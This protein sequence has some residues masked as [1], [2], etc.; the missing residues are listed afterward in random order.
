MSSN[1]VFI[2]FDNNPVSTTV[3]SNTSNEAIPAGQYGLIIPHVTTDG[4]LFI[5]DVEA[6]VR[7]GIY[8]GSASAQASGTTIYNNTTT[9]AMIITVA[10]EPVAGATTCTINHVKGGVTVPLRSYTL[11]GTNLNQDQYLQEYLLD[12][13]DSLTGTTDSNAFDYIYN[14]YIIGEKD[15]FQSPIWVPSGTDIRISAGALYTLII[16]N[17]IT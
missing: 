6:A 17:E 11:V 7:S 2:P 1:N 12:A 8:S 16:Y 14:G 13:G 4:K 5:D 10:V 15:S 9:K 3:K